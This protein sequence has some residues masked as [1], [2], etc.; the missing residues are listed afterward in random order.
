MMT[1][2]TPTFQPTA[3]I[4]GFALRYIQGIATYQN[5]VSNDAGILLQIYT[6]DLIFV[7]EGKTNP[8]GI[9]NIAVPMERAFWMV[10]SAEGYRTERIYNTESVALSDITLLA[11]DLNGDECINADDIALMRGQFHP[12]NTVFDLNDDKKI[13]ISD[14]AMLAGNLNPECIQKIEITSTPDISLT[15]TIATI[16]STEFTPTPMTAIS[17]TATESVI[18]E[19]TELPTVEAETTELP[20][21]EAEATNEP[22]S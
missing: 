4:G 14:V 8:D 21:V 19:T 12:S 15:P 20:T 3:T 9:Y 7:S 11:G 13:D 6:D 10:F 17:P 5:H 16:D 2:I 1:T 22:E 18:V